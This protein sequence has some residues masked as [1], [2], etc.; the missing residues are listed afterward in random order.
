MDHSIKIKGISYW[1]QLLFAAGLIVSFF[2]SWVSW[3]G[4][5]VNGS[6]LPSGNFFRISASKFGLDNPFPQFSFTFFVFWLIPVLAGIAA[7]LVLLKKR[8]IPFSY[9]AGALSLTL[10]TIFILF[11][12]TLID[13]G[14]GKSVWSML[15][16][17]A[18][19]HALSAIG[20]IATVSPVKKQYLKLIFLIIGPVFAYTG[21]KMGEKVVMNETYKTTDQVKTD[22]TI[23]AADLLKEFITNDTSANKKYTEKT[24]LLNGSAS[25]IEILEDSTST[26]KFSD[27]TGSYAIFSLE[28]NQIEKVKT[29]QQGNSVSVKGVCSGSIYSEILGTT[30]ITFKRAI[31][32]H[33]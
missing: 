25:A 30:A 9:I 27:S 29:L 7:G 19:I 11:T 6:A 3:S 17:P 33:K 14:V 8:T 26:I 20:L 1:L 22:F 4:V 21:Y 23:E 24:I 32:I 12:S 2:F 31:L 18:Y 28:K 16:F 13:L 15:K 5:M 10:I